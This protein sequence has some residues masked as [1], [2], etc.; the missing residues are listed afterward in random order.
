MKALRLTWP[1]A[2]SPSLSGST[3]GLQEV[4]QGFAVL[5]P[6]N[7][8]QE[9]ESLQGL[10]LLA[11]QASTLRGLHSSPPLTAPEGSV[12]GPQRLRLL[13]ERGSKLR[14]SALCETVTG[15]RELIGFKQHQISM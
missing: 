10:I 14:V 9:T 12:A 11:I 8:N 4:E 13:R 7:W 1:G 6:I 3:V 2:D 5:Y 15:K